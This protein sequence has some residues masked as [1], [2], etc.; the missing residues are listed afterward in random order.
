MDERLEISAPEQHRALGHPLRHRI[1]FAIGQ[2]AA[3]I[4]QLAKA[5]GQRKGNIAHHLGVLQAAGLATVVETR[6]VRGGT[7]HYY[8]RTARRLVFTG[9]ES[10]PVS[11]RAVADDLAGAGEVPGFRIRNLRLTREQARAAAAAL[12]SLIDGLEDAGDAGARYEI[13]CTLFQ[14]APGDSGSSGSSGSSDG[15]QDSRT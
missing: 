13:L 6:Q 2:Q 14:P 12:E 10:G 7:E 3:T 11:V 5:L 15:D 4:S 8:L 1:L 9:P